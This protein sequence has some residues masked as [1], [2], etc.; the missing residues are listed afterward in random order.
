[1]FG[2]RFVESFATLDSRSHIADDVA[3]IALA[4]VGRIAPV[5]GG[6]RLDE[7][8]GFNHGSLTGG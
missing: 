4:F 6:Q 7:R 5:K 1:M 2:D 3:E 8:F